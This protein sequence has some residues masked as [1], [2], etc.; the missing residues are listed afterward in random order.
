MKQ[1][2]NAKISEKRRNAGN[3]E[4]QSQQAAGYS[5]SLKL[6]NESRTKVA[7][8]APSLSNKIKAIFMGLLAI[9]VATTLIAY[10]LNSGEGAYSVGVII[11]A[12]ILVV[13]FGLFA[14]RRYK[15]A[16]RGLPFEDERSRKVLE[17][18]S[19]TSFYVTLYLLL[20]IGILSEDLINFRDVAQATS[21][22]VGGMV[23]LFFIFWVY[24]NR[25]EI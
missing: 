5:L 21:A 23:I 17:K 25:K 6:E 4:S 2:H 16:D 7:G 11:I 18:A 15:D 19:L 20:A 24:Y 9:V 3:K 8:I 22:A 13:L 10:S 12:A 1:K 14:F